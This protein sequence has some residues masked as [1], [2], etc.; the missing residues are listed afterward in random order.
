M[1]TTHR[2]IARG[3]FVNLSHVRDDL[4]VRIECSQDF[5]C[6][7]AGRDAADRF[8]RGSAAAALPVPNAVFRFVGE[9]GVRRTKV[10]CISA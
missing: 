2:S 9:V 6:D 3:D 4:E 1:S 10:D 7:R 8:A 5:A